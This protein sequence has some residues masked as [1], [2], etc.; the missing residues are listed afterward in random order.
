MDNKERF[1]AGEM[2]VID[3]KVG[4]FYFK[5]GVIFRET[6]GADKCEGSCIIRETDFICETSMMSVYYRITTAFTDLDFDRL[7]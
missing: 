3:G 2:F 7:V 6:F 5:D 4:G 1:K